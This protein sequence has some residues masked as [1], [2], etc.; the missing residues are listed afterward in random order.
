MAINPYITDQAN[1]LAQQYN[2]N[3][4]NNVLPSIG[5][6]AIAAG[7]FGGSRQGIAQG[8]AAGQSQIGLSSALANLY[9]GAYENDQNRQLQQ[10]GL[11][12]QYALGQGQLALGNRQADNSYSLGL[13]QLG[14]GQQAQNTSQYNA[15]TNRGLGYGQLQ[16]T[17]DQNAFNNQL[18]GYNA[19]LNG[20]NALMNWN[21]QGVNLA[22]QQQQTPITNLTNLTNIGTTVGGQGG[23]AST[24]YYGNP[25]LGALA[26]ASLGNSVGSIDWSKVFGG[27]S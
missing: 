20:L 16:Q 8:L 7:G 24:P 2:N 9:G 15:E 3:L 18:Q 10:Q 14:I 26:G 13:G 27:G 1:A 23:T 12:N 11:N 4:Q 17:G 6:N 22:N 21:A 25:L 5:S 19:Q